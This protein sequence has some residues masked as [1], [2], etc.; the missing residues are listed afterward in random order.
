MASDGFGVTEV[1]VVVAVS[2]GASDGFE[3]DLAA[4]D[5]DFSARA[6]DLPDFF[7]FLFY[8]F[9]TTRLVK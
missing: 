1:A 4:L 8:R 7:F 5:E 3:C 2:F 9:G 6:T